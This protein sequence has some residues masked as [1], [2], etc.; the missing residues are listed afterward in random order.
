MNVY[1]YKITALY[2]NC[3][4]TSFRELHAVQVIRMVTIYNFSRWTA[5]KSRLI[6]KIG[7]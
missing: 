5:Y 4:W 3:I 6:S 1:F 7:N 2:K